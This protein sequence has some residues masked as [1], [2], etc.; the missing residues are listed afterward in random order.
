M[1][2]LKANPTFKAKVG[3]PIPGGE[4][5]DV[6][7]E[8]KHRT[9]EE[10]AEFIKASASIPDDESILQVCVGWGLD[11]AFTPENVRIFTENYHRASRAVAVKYLAELTQVR[12]G[13]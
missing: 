13:N 5:V 12:L 1:L 4:P 7:F 9:K 11:D 2:K 3:I 8:F 6:E 10:L